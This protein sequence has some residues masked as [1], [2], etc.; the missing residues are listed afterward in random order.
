MMKCTDSTYIFW[1]GFLPMLWWKLYSE[2]NLLMHRLILHLEHWNLVVVCLFLVVHTWCCKC[3]PATGH[4]SVG[5]ASRPVIWLACGFGLDWGW[6]SLA[7]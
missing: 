4:C 2:I 5:W 7:L 6:R 3:D 1:N